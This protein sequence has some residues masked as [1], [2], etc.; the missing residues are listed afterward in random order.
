MNGSLTGVLQAVMNFGAE[1]G[2]LEAVCTDEDSFERGAALDD[3]D[4]RVRSPA[5]RG[6]RLTAVMS[7]VTLDLRE[8]SL[9][10]DGATISV[11]SALTDIEILVPRDWDVVCDIDAVFG[12]IQSQRF[13]PLSSERRPRLRL[14]GMVVAG[15]V[16]V[17]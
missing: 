4:L 14:T 15:G 17:R 5:F 1:D 10:E 8:A 7:D 2:R 3:L 16:C 6:G 13:P 9:S 12:G 11:Q